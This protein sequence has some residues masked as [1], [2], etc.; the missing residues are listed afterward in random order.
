[1]QNNGEEE[2]PQTTLNEMISSNNQMVPGQASEQKI[3]TTQTQPIVTSQVTRKVITTTQQPVIESTY[4]SKKITKTTTSTRGT[5]SHPT[6][7]ISGRYQNISSTKKPTETY[8]RPGQTIKT[9]TTTTTTIQ[10]GQYNGG[11]YGQGKV[12]PKSN[13]NS[14][15]YKTNQ[16]NPQKKIEG[17]QT[18][19]GNNYQPKRPEVVSYQQKSKSPEPGS[20]KK[21]T[22][23]RGEPIENI[24]ITHIIF[25][26]RPTDFHITETLNLDNLD[27]DPIKITEDDRAKLQQIGKVEVKCSCDNVKI[28]PPKKVDLKGNIIVYQHARGIGMTN[29]KKENINPKF[30]TSEIKEMKPIHRQKEKEKIEHIEIFRS[31][32][33]VNNKSPVRTTQK[34]TLTYNRGGS[35]YTQNQNYRS[36]AG[37]SSTYNRGM[38]NSSSGRGGMTNTVPN[39]GGVSTTS[40]IVSNYTRGNNDGTGKNGQIIKETTTKIQTGSRSYQ[41]QSQPRTYT[42]TEKRVY[43]NQHNFSNK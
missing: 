19:S 16:R 6:Q 22:I 25:S 21:R 13:V 23:N 40:K 9:T 20:I 11:Q 12:I 37:N 30:Y 27:S 3:T 7:N 14:Q 8:S 43:N 2:Q 41:N 36:G 15:T 33:Q 18:Y 1:M 4:Y 17:S 26:S 42:T 10:R 31:S 34:T 39:R 32:G 38:T 35:N 28:N 5:E 29:D 24:Q